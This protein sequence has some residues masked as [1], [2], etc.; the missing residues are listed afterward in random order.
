MFFSQEKIL[1]LSE[2]PLTAG[3]ECTSLERYQLKLIVYNLI[4][5]WNT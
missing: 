5:P 2:H 4:D 3:K 1:H